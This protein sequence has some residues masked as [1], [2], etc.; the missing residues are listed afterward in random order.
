MNKKL[1]IAAGWLVMAGMLTG[2]EYKELTD[3][4]DNSLRPKK[5]FLVDFDFKNVD[6]IPPSMRVVFWPTDFVMNQSG[7]TVFD[8]LNKETEL[9]LPV[10]TYNVTTWNNNTE[11]VIYSIQG[12]REE[13]YATTGSYSPHGNVQIPKVLDSL[14]NG[15][16]VLDYPDYMVHAN[17]MGFQLINDGAQQKLMLDVDSMVVTVEV[18]LKG[19][20]GL[21]WCQNIRGAINN[22]AGKRLMAFP[23]A[24]DEPVTIMFDGQSHASDNTVTAKFYVFGIEPTNITSLSHKMVFFFWLTGGQVFIPMDVTNAIHRYNREDKYVYI[25]SPE[26]DIDLRKYMVNGDTGIIVD[27]D[28]WEEGGDIPL[29]F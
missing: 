17:R 8:V 4:D 14:Y 16:K 5:K 28:D 12:N 13:T 15:Q 3:I 6:N 20:A 10:G 1:Y 26:L 27:A 23:N 11:Y 2:C 18:K 22:V 29:T 21:E 25:E 19:V 9:E 7:Y 24:T